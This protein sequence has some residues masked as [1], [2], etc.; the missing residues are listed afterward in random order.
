MT[1]DHRKYGTALDPVRQSDLS[2]LAGKYGCP[3]K[4]ARRKRA[5]EQ[6]RKSV[7][8]RMAFGTAVHGAMEMA[9]DE[10]MPDGAQ[11][12]AVYDHALRN[13]D[14]GL[15]VDWY[16]QDPA[17]VRDQGITMIRGA[18]ADLERRGVKPVESEAQ[19]TAS[20][21]GYAKTGTIDLIYRRPIADV[22]IGFLDWK[23]G[24]MKPSQIDL[25]YGYQLG[26]YAH[27]VE[28]GDFDPFEESDGNPSYGEAPEEIA[29]VHL[30]D[31]L[32]YAKRTT[33]TIDRPEELTWCREMASSQFNP[34]PLLRIGDRVEIEPLDQPPPKLKKDGTPY[35]RPK[36]KGQ[37][38]RCTLRSGQR[39]P[40]WYFAK[41]R[42][43]ASLDRLSVSL[44]T[45]VGTV[46]LGR[47]YESIGE[48]CA[49]C[50]FKDACLN[51]APA[52][53]REEQRKMNELL[54]GVE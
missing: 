9:L 36:R 34:F 27:A 29:I 50:P 42:T 7:P 49:R 17:P 46:R 45:I 4:F 28:F 53:D 2:D 43:R 41:P 8:W 33:I 14:G 38:P 47:F 11:L 16:D 3:A 31:Y 21:A 1:W 5:A 12:G 20:L 32:P 44:S 13:V 15:P 6:V 24:Q 26:M 35:A 10:T 54:R 39:G 23:T 52:P 40:G 51:D 22:G 48:G 18:L 37:P 25:D 19:F 30:R